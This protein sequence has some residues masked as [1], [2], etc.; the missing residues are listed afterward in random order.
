MLESRVPNSLLE[1]IINYLIP[2]SL[3]LKSFRAL[4]ISLSPKIIFSKS[5]IFGIFGVSKFKSGLA[6]TLF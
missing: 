2:L 3:F 5:Y 1:L 4:N 6:F